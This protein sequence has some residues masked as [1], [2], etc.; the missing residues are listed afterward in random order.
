MTGLT[1]VLRIDVRI[2]LAAGYRAIV[3]TDAIGGNAGVVY[4][5]A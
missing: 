4:A 2:T 3:T 5:G 1:D